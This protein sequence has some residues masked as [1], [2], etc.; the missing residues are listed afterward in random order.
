M[1]ILLAIF[2]SLL[3]IVAVELG[4]FFGIGRSVKNQEVK[5]DNH[6]VSTPMPPRV[7]TYFD[8]G[9]ET[10]HRYYDQ[11]RDFIQS[12]SINMTFAGSLK[13]IGDHEITLTRDHKD[14]TLTAT[15]DSIK[16]SYFKAVA[17]RPSA[18]PQ[19]IRKEELK[20]GDFVAVGVTVSPG[21]EANITSVLDIGQ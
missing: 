12:A 7:Q 15:S 19:A 4:Y 20:A 14:L 8:K 5:V 2:G 21:G 10:F 17:R 13:S 11:N 1:R 18:T 6:S 9:W 3:I 16:T